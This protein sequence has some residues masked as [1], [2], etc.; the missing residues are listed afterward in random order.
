[1]PRGKS[2]SS[3]AGQGSKADL[4]VRK[5][6]P[7]DEWAGFVPCELGVDGREAFDVWCT[8][9]GQSFARLIDDALG[10]GLKL[11]MSYD[12]QNQCY[13]AC[14]SGRPDVD[15]EI[16][17]N[18]ILSGRAGTFSQAL[19]VLVYKHYELLRLAWWDSLNAPK[20]NRRSFG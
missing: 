13:V 3:G 19:Q 14:F 5:A 8:G 7:K 15:G 12:G 4:S 2:G 18:A 10:T 20:V 1:M 16:A 17:F 11:T 6:R 9:M